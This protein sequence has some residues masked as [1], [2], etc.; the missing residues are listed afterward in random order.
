MNDDLFLNNV[1][2]VKKIVKKMDYGYVDKDDLYQAGL[3]GLYKST[4]KY[5]VNLNDDFLSFASIYIINEIK[6]ELRNNKLIKLNKKIIKIK[7]YLKDNNAN[8]NSIDE[9]ANI[10]NVSKEII[11][12]SYNYMNDIGSLND[13]QENEEL[14]N[15]IS[16]NNCNDSLYQYYIEKLDYLSKEIIILKYYKNYTQ[17]EIA[18]ILNCSQSTVSRIEKNALSIIRKKLC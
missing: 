8:N 11:I 7:K 6:N 15:L 4:L 3:I 17:A 5:N 16:D 18:K 10:F 13:L 2:F 12:L 14:I 1:D 9:I